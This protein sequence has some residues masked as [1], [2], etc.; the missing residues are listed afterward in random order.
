MKITVQLTENELHHTEID[1]E[2]LQEII[3]QVVDDVVYADEINVV[4]EIIK[5]AK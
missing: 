1:E 3:H 4:I 5:D 2:A